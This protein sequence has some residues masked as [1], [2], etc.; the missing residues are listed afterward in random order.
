MAANILADILRNSVFDQREVDVER[1][2][3]LQEIGQTLDTPDDIVFDWLQRRLIQ[4]NL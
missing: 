2:V 1:G 3:I 4:N